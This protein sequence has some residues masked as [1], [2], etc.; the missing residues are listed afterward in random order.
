MTDVDIEFVG[1]PLDG[2]VSCVRAMATG[3]PPDRFTIDV[4]TAGGGGHANHNYQAGSAPNARGRWLYEYAGI[5][6]ASC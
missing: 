2:V 4:I 6:S 1:G 3:Q 5:R